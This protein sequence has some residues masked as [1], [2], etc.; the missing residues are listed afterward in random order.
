MLHENR[1]QK[2]I[3]ILLVGGNPGPDISG[4]VITIFPLVL[5]GKP[6]PGVI[7]SSTVLHLTLTLPKILVAV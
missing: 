2:G 4:H 6:F 5:A 7:A 1:A 3:S